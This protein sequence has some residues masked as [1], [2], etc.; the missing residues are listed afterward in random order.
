MS[1]GLCP[2]RGRCWKLERIR[3]QSLDRLSSLAAFVQHCK[4]CHFLTKNSPKRVKLCI[5]PEAIAPVLPDLHNAERRMMIGLRELRRGRRLLILAERTM[6]RL[7]I[8]LVLIAAGLH[9]ENFVFATNSA[10]YTLGSDGV[11]KSLT[12]KKTGKEW[13]TPNLLPMFDVR[14]GGKDFVSSEVKK[15]GNVLHVTFGASGI[16]ADISITPH[17][18]YLVAEVVAVAGAGVEELRM[19]ELRVQPE[20]AGTIIAVRSNAE[21]TVCLMGLSDKVDTKTRADNAVIASVYPETG[22]LHEKVA[23]IA[24]PTPRFYEVVQAVERDGQL[25][26]PKIGGAWAKLAPDVRTSY[27]FTDLNEANVDE[28]IRYAKLGG[29]RYIL[30]YAPIWAATNGSYPISPQSYPNGERGLKAVIDRCHAAGLKVGMHMLTSFIDKRDPLVKPKPDPRLL[31]DA[32]AVLATDVSALS[33]EVSADALKDFG[34]ESALYG[35]VK[36]G[37]DIQI[38]DEIIQYRSVSG[39]KLLGCTRGANGTQPASHQAGAKIYHLA[40]RYNSYLA[41]LKTTLKDEISDR[42][43]GLINR[44]GFDM[45]YF[46]G[47]EVNGVNGPGYYY[48]GLQQRGIY[49]RVKRDVLYQGSGTSPYSWHILTRGACDDTSA[50]DSKQ[51]LDLH[52][53]GEARANYLKSFMPSELGW[54]GLQSAGPDHPPTMPDEVE[55]HAVRMLALDSPISLE[56][57]LQALKSNARTEELLRL[58]GSYETLRL[59]GQVPQALRNKLRTGEWHMMLNAGKV[60]FHPVHYTPRQASVPAEITLNNEFGA[61]PLKFRLHGMTG[62]TPVGDQRNITIYRS[63]QGLTI[64]PPA[65]SAQMPGALVGH[66]QLSASGGS[67]QSALMVG[68][69]AEKTDKPLEGKAMNLLRNRVL[70]VTLDFEGPVSNPPAVLNIQLE[71]GAKTNRDFYVNLDF[72]GEKTIRLA[73]TEPGRMLSEFRPANSNYSFKMS[74]SGF[75]WDDVDALNFRWM[76]QAQGQPVRCTVKS[77]EALAEADM[78]TEPIQISVGGGSVIV[79][80]GLKPDDYAEYWADGSVRTFDQNGK[81]LATIPVSGTPPTLQAG[82]NKVSLTSPKPARVQLTE[83]VMGPALSQ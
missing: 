60:E 3:L 46:D 61:Q 69:G 38:G 35:A 10:Q 44:C 13:L 39:T 76:R 78:T 21:F 12:D 72:T 33:T 22:M 48:L 66:V 20:N 24:V 43:S 19:A 6:H 2:R 50:L 83:I 36:A 53:I 34:S 1:F 51:Y 23:I 52:K 55:F 47:G 42:I 57:T 71:A 32:S 54:W 5:N 82:A 8:S 77:V 58:L 45:I 70:V 18:D 68:T 9:A 11:S 7:L 15:E 73:M 81:L 31:K 59:G 30:I 65:A 28:T 56:T 29:F 27:L 64:P 40:E 25:P 75:R 26:A 67:R 79:P 74:M 49:E 63:A 16:T 41:D 14:V 17:G 37:R 80:A 4:N 62:L